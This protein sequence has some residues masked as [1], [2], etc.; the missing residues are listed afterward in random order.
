MAQSNRF[1][2]AGMLDAIHAAVRATV[3]T[4]ATKSSGVSSAEQNNIL[5]VLAGLK[6]CS[7][8]KGRGAG[9][10]GYKI[11]NRQYHLPKICAWCNGEGWIDPS[12][13]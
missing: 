8:C 13:D 6:R 1:R 2:P 12:A 4:S 9:M 5:R 3:K 11:D 10:K 7:A